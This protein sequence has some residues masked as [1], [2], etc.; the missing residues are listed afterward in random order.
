MKFS[1]ILL[2]ATVLT[3][4]SDVIQSLENVGCLFSDDLCEQ[5]EV[6]LDDNA[7]GRCEGVDDL[8]DP[9]IS[10]T[11]QHSLSAKTLRLLENEMQRLYIS[12]YRWDNDYTQCV[13]KQILY[14]HRLGINY[15]PG[16]CSRL[17]KLYSPYIAPETSIDLTDAKSL[18]NPLA[19]IDFVPDYESEFAKEVF[20]RVI[21][22]NEYDLK[23]KR[24][25]DNKV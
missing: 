19:D 18:P 20:S 24:R 15:D 11:Y 12:G 22:E 4:S 17:L 8:N 21:D 7:F 25:D 9:E 5:L 10:V 14:T 23:T 6:C 13:I 16:L 3:F 1:L 2:L